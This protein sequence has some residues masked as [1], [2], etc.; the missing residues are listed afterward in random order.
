VGC[1]AVIEGHFNAP[2][3]R[4]GGI[5]EI[6]VERRQSYLKLLCIQL[7]DFTKWVTTDAFC[8]LVWLQPKTTVTIT[9]SLCGDLNESWV[10]RQIA[11]ICANGELKAMLKYIGA[12]YK[13]CSRDHTNIAHIS[14]DIPFCTQ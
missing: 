2:A 12:T 8:A 5:S 3:T 10:Y 4:A 14:A 7:P 1:R 9:G 11:H 6:C 13:L